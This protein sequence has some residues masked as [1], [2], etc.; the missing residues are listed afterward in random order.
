MDD[1]YLW[2]DDI[3][4]PAA[5][6][7]FTFSCS[8]FVSVFFVLF[9]LLLIS[10][11]LRHC[12]MKTLQPIVT[13]DGC[14]I[15]VCSS[16]FKL[17][18]ITTSSFPAF[19]SYISGVQHF[20]WDVCVCDYFRSNHW[21]SHIP[22]SWVVHAGCVFVAGIHPSRTWMSGSLESVQWN[23]CEHRLDLGFLLS[24][25]SVL[26]KWSQIPCY[27]QGKNSLYQKNSPLR[28]IKYMLSSAVPFSL[29][30]DPLILW[31]SQA[32]CW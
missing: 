26:G 19:P 14:L 10:D 23:A 31:L 32:N 30:V 12:S 5:I 4:S 17:Q 20:G 16:S 22:S 24:S 6:V 7:S 11:Y 3:L 15:D 21:G 8:F 18:S 25:E 9:L 27:L 1:F 2:L 13:L 29:P 28:S